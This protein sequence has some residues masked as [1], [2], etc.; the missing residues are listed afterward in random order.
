MSNLEKKI[1][2]MV[3]LS[4]SHVTLWSFD[5]KE[6]FVTLKVNY[7]CIINYIRNINFLINLEYISIMI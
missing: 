2:F 5:G 4:C 7:I 3:Y 1:I 6:Y